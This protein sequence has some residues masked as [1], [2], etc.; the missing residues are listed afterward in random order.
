MARLFGTDGVRGI[1]NTELTPE[2]VYSIGFAHGYRLRSKM[3]GRPKVV[4][5]RDTRIS[6]ALLESSYAAGLCAAGADAVIIGVIPTPAVAWYVVHT[7]AQG[8]GVISA[9]HNPGRNHRRHAARE[10]QRE[11]LGHLQPRHQCHHQQPDQ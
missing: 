1:A 7:Q 11:H 6:G 9:S 2:L 5:G 3:N 10:E 8:G 4:V